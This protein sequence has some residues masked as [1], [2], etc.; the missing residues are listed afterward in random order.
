MVDGRGL[1]NKVE[2][3]TL[4]VCPNSKTPEK[5]HIKPHPFKAIPTSGIDFKQTFTTNYQTPST[6]YKQHT[7][8]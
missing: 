6:T 1:T 3:I 8:D 4:T 7:Q 2:L 5:P